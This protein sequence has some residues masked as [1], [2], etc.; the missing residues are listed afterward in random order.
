MFSS[1]TK[2]E[3]CSYT[4]TINI[5]I[6]FGHLD[7]VFEWCKANTQKRWEFYLT[8]HSTIL[9]P[10]YTF[11]FESEKDLTM[12]ALRWNNVYS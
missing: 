3:H 4:N 2:Q 12:F 7:E 10:Q 1:L 5:V 11:Y 8:Q 9:S 6:R